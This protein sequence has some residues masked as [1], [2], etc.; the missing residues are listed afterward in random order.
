M[1]TPSSA[2]SLRVN[3]G[4]AEGSVWTSMCRCLAISN[5]TARICSWDR[6]V[7]VS[8]D[9]G[10]PLSPESTSCADSGEERGEENGSTTPAGVAAVP[11]VLPSS[12]HFSS[13]ACSDPPV[14]SLLSAWA[15]N[16]GAR[17]RWSG[18][19]ASN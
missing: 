10:K 13:P 17:W 16:C 5:V 8:Y 9:D 14:G 6:D 11:A 3:V 18:L 7:T 12:P 4:T 15:P 19:T 1:V 2:S